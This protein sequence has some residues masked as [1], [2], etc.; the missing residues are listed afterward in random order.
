[1]AEIVCCYNVL[2][3]PYIVAGRALRFTMNG[4]FSKRGK[5]SS[6]QLTQLLWFLFYPHR[7]RETR[8]GDMLRDEM[9]MSKNH[10]PAIAVKRGPVGQVSQTPMFAFH[11]SP[12]EACFWV[13]SL[14]RGQALVALET[15][16]VPPG[17]FIF[18][19]GTISRHV[20]PRFRSLSRER[21]IAHVNGKHA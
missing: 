12:I 10:S 2:F 3:P 4:L 9:D 11:Y 8:L 6:R 1:M 5:G 7:Y 15:W 17:S 20:T 13:Y 18:L 19:P 21:D 16:N 14:L